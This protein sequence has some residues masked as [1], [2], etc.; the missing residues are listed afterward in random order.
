MHARKEQAKPTWRSLAV[1][2]VFDLEIFRLDLEYIPV[3]QVVATPVLPLSRRGR[4]LVVTALGLSLVLVLGLWDAHHEDMLALR[5]LMHEH[6]LLADTLSTYIDINAGNVRVDSL[7]QNAEETAAELTTFGQ[8]TSRVERD[9]GFIVLLMDPVRGQYLTSRH[10][11]IHVHDLEA[12][13]AH[14]AAGALLSRDAA[15]LEGYPTGQR[16]RALLQSMK[17]WGAIARLP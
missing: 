10:R 17:N 15:T 2:C 13:Q 4:T 3:N 14:E 6:H 7:S 12:A 8:A 5:Q 1:H 11:W 16:W 9:Q